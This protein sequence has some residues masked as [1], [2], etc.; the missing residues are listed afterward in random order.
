MKIRDYGVKGKSNF[1][2]TV[3]SKIKYKEQV[4]AQILQQ[5]MKKDTD[6]AKKDGR[7]YDESL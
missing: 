3:N 2:K 7:T 4:G 6:E 1:K 5:V